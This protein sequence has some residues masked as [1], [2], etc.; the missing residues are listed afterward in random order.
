MPV[1]AIILL[2]FFV[3]SLPVCLVRPFYGILLWTIVA[4]LNPQA[5]IWGPTAFPWALAVA[6]P[7]LAGCLCFAS[8]WSRRL[9]SREVFLILA[10]WLWFT[11]TSEVSTNTALFIHHAP[12]TWARWLFVSKVLLMTVVTIGIVDSFAKLRILVMVASGCFGFFVLKSFPFI[13]STGGAFRLYGPANSMV[14]DNNDLGLALNMTLPL[15]YFLAQAE[16][17]RSVKW[18]YRFLFFIT[19]PAIFFTYSRGAL[20]AL[21]A[22]LILMVLRSRRGLLLV[23]AVVMGLVI[24]FL[25]APDAWKDRMDP[26]REGALDASAQER[27]NAWNFAWNL[28]SEFPITGG[29]F[30]TFTPELFARYAPVAVDVHGP[31]SV[32]FGVLGEHGFIGLGLYLALVVSFFASA[33]RLAKLARLHGDILVAHYVNMFR[34]SAVG[35]LVSGAFLGRAYFDYWFFIVAC[36]IILKN[37]AIDVWLQPH[38]DNVLAENGVALCVE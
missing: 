8:G 29:G 35:F 15:F 25:F 18:L 13:I 19:I 28:A 32:Y 23:P 22:V 31:H 16:T 30:G 33:R 4:F 5:F 11:I 14:A 24:A 2:A 26:T 7:T 12:E 1:R 20:V 10:L 17:N 3:A 37:V 34:F 9:V 6:I 38:D 36:L 27:L 21:A